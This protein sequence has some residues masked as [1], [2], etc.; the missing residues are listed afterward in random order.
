MHESRIFSHLP[1]FFSTPS[2]DVRPT[3]AGRFQVEYRF[4]RGS[5]EMILHAHKSK[6]PRGANLSDRVQSL[7][8]CFHLMLSTDFSQSNK[9]CKACCTV[10]SNRNQDCFNGKTT[11]PTPDFQAKI[12]S[13]FATKFSTK[14][15]PKAQMRTTVKFSQ[16]YFFTPKGMMQIATR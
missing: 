16:A 11:C 7:Q 2:S 10:A 12:A 15:K 4:S 6:Y 1:D 9:R 13:L 5:G 3:N 8:K 14:Q